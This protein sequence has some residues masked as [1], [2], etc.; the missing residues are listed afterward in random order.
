MMTRILTLALLGGV[1]SAPVRYQSPEESVDWWYRIETMPWADRGAQLENSIFYNTYRHMD[2]QL[3]MYGY[4]QH[5]GKIYRGE[6]SHPENVLP[7]HRAFGDNSDFNHQ[8]L[9]SG[10]FRY[11]P[12]VDKPETPK[13]ETPKPETPKPKWGYT[14]NQGPAFWGAMYPTCL[15]DAQSPID[16]NVGDMSIQN[17]PNKVRFVGYDLDSDT[18][19][20][21]LKNNGHSVELSI[22]SPVAT[23]PTMD[24]GHLTDEYEFVQLHFHWGP[25]DNSGSEHTANGGYAMPLEMHLVHVAKTIDRHEFGGLAV[26]A[27]W[28]VIVDEEN[29]DIEPIISGISRIKNYGQHTRLEKGFKLESLIS[30]TFGDQYVTYEGSLTTPGCDE[31]VQWNIF[32]L[33]L[34]ISKSQLARFRTILDSEGNPVLSNFRPVQPLNGRTVKIWK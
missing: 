15:G 20:Y 14:G 25:D 24:G 9:G 29:P 12:H 23:K 13:L 10:A 17:V 22:V 30:Y 11:G 4:A 18:T 6:Y 33:G 21:E 31:V 28:F 7:A 34:T 26:A 19:E 32:N 2:K 1:L 3:D 27:F 16:L 5:T 8:D